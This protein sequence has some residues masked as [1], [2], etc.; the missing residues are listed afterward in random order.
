VIIKHLF[1]GRGRAYIKF[2]DRPFAFLGDCSTVDLQLE[3][4]R[5]LY[6]EHQTIEGNV[7]AQFQDNRKAE[8][9]IVMAEW[10]PTNM[11]IAT[12]GTIQAEEEDLIVAGFSSGA[13]E[14]YLVFQGL[15]KVDGLPVLLEI[16]CA[17]LEP[18]QVIEFI[19]SRPTE[20]FQING[21]AKVLDDGVP[22]RLH[23]ATQ[24]DPLSFTFVDS[25]LGTDS[26]PEMGLYLA[27]QDETQWTEA[28]L[29]LSRDGGE[30]FEE[31]WP[32]VNRS[33]FGI[34]T[35]PVGDAN[36]NFEDHRTVI[37]A[38]M[39]AG[40][41]GLRSLSLSDFYSGRMNQIVFGAPGRWEIARFQ[42]GTIDVN[43]V[44]TFRQLIRG[45]RGTEFAVDQHQVGDRLYLMRDYDGTPAM[46][47]VPLELSD[48]NQRLWFKLVL[49]GQSIEDVPAVPFT[50]QGV[51]LKPYAPMNLHGQRINEDWHLDLTRRS[52]FGADDFSQEVPLVATDANY[53]WE[54]ETPNE[55]RA[56]VSNQERVV[57]GRSLQL[58]DFNS[59]LPTQL[60]IKAFLVS[61]IVGLGYET[62]ATIQP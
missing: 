61:D 8:I 15:N 4:D 48:L 42:V 54:I 18:S 37:K 40:G 32:I 6:Y 1:N 46:E 34:V 11:A 38:Q 50:P 53:R 9:A 43:G 28:T 59:V 47:R 30:T 3:T 60:R 17:V 12:H 31:Y 10:R 55:V 49:A 44:A 22:F 57:Y 33:A 20:A 45:T 26:D 27:V 58:S 52:R 24:L 14:V 7:I 2:A 39:V 19:S 41:Q 21:V 51:G 5:T 23:S 13:P 62:T 29:H 16:P 35:E 36:R 56:L 25:N